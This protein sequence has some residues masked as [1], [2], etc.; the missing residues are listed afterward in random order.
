[1]H[2]SEAINIAI[3]I[4]SR[5]GSSRLKGKP[6]EMVLGK[7][8]IRRV[9]EIASA[10]RGVDGVY[11]ATDDERI[12]RHVKNFGGRCIMT[13]AACANGTERV[14]AAAQ[15]LDPVPDAVINF[16]GDA[17]LTPPWV[18]EKLVDALR[19]DASPAIVTPAVRMDL[20]EYR[21]LLRRKDPGAA[22]GTMVVFDRNC[23]ALYFSKSVIPFLRRNGAGPLPDPAPI[24]R[25]VGLYGYRIDVLGQY[26]ALEPGPL[27]AVEQL[28]QLRALEHGIPVRVVEVDYRGRSHGSIDTPDDIEKAEAIIR[29]EG[30]LL[31]T[32]A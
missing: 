19:M 5:Y 18:V 25:H 7:S 13:P 32:Q 6:L 28:E 17:V 15:T 30:E 27:E 31:E 16:Q 11:V 9:W 26:L 12:V 21:R 1:M 20:R 22:G 29:R 3:V 4:P 23:K 8:V 10:V 24:Y 2:N 14:F